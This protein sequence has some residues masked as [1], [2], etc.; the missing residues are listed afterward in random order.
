MQGLPGPQN[1]VKQDWETY[2]DPISKV[3][4]GP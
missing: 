1:T 2:G 3:R 4:K